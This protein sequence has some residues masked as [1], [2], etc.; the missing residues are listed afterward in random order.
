MELNKPKL[1]VHGSYIGTTGYNNHTRDFFRELSK[2]VQLKIKNF[3]VGSSWNGNNET[4]HDRE[5]YLTNTDKSLLY[6]QRLWVECELGSGFEV[7][8]IELSSM[9]KISMLVFTDFLS[10]WSCNL[11]DGAAD[12]R[13]IV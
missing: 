11:W 4:P 6:K 2:H 9:A 3:T 1:Y 12:L 5:P 10:T 8:T 13:M 7:D